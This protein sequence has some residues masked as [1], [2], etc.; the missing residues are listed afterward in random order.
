MKKASIIKAAIGLAVIAGGL[1]FF[2]PKSSV[3]T[4][5]VEFVVR[6]DITIQINATGTVQPENRLEIKPPIAGRIEDMLVKEGEVVKKGQILAWMSSTERAALLDAARAQGEQEYKKWEQNYRP[7][8]VLSPMDGT[9]ILKNME[10]G[11]TLTTSDPI[12][13]LSNRLTV[14]AQVDETDIAQIKLGQQCQIVLD[15]YPQHKIPAK[16]S[17]MAYEAVTTNNVTTYTIDVTPEN[18]PEFTRSGMTANVFFNVES[19]EQALVIP[20][21]AISY[22]DNKKFVL[23]GPTKEKIQSVQIQTGLSDGRVTEVKSGLK[24][25]DAIYLPQLNGKTEQAGG[26]PLNPFGNRRGKR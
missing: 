15:A 14:K 16:V 1:I 7:T 26:N 25:G 19:I 12:V 10:S 4:Y 2:L 18:T 9:I 6:S 13:V 8:P 22:K 24:E 17:Q 5:Q 20:N 23:T 21:A 3:E 11:Q